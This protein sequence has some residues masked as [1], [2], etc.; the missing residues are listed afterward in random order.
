M[1]ADAPDRRQTK[2]VWPAETVHLRLCKR[3]SQSD[4][5]TSERKADGTRWSYHVNR[6]R[7]A[8][9]SSPK[10][11]LLR[12]AAQRR[13]GALAAHALGALRAKELIM[14]RQTRLGLDLTHIGP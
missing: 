3:R 2:V 13:F 6:L 8:D 7:W 4:W 5:Q 9:D 14:I 10:V 11:C 12:D 1:T